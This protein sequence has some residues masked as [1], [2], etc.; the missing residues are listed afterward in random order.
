MADLEKETFH[1]L[2][3]NVKNSVIDDF[4]VTLRKGSNVSI[5]S[6]TNSPRKPSLLNV[7]NESAQKSFQV[8]H[9]QHNGL[10]QQ[11]EGGENAN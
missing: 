8:Q 4:R 9:Y 6:A 2:F 11:K 3:D 1:S 7:S 5:A 10:R